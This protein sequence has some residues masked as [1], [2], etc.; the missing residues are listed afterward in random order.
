ME[1]QSRKQQEQLERLRKDL[2]SVAMATTPLTGIDPGFFCQSSVQV[3]FIVADFLFA[4][5][6][7]VA[8]PSDFIMTRGNHDDEE[9]EGLDSDTDDLDHTGEKV[10][11]GN[12]MSGTTST[13]F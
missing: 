5:E 13:V 2:G 10:S 1:A 12:L 11:C 4:E 9:E 3:H 6:A 8:G 7:A